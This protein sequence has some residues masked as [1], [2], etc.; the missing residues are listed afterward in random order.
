MGYLPR[1]VCPESLAGFETNY[2]FK[3]VLACCAVKLLSTADDV[4]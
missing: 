2:A 1:P 4:I 3:A